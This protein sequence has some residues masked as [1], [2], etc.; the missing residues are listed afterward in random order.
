MHAA[1][2]CDSALAPAPATPLPSAMNAT[3][4]VHSR[5]MQGKYL[6][7]I[8]QQVFD[9]LEQ[10]KYQLSEYRLSIYGSKKDEWDVLAE[11]VV[12]HKLYSSTVRWMI[13]IPRLY[14]IYKASGQIKNF[15]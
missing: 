2:P 15:A 5:P 1:A 9:D 12:D 8:T 6:A 14:S 11:W 7:E 13:Q 3:D 4:C 10:N